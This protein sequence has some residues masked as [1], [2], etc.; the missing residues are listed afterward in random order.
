MSLRL[1]G[2]TPEAPT[3]SR[4]GC[5]DDAVWNVNWRNPKIHGADRVKI[6]LACGDHREF[7]SEFLAARD[8]PVQVTPLGVHLDRV[9]DGPAAPS[10]GGTA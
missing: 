8:F 4:S 9:P 1:P 6:W 2:E 3:C 10:A 7:L 5:T